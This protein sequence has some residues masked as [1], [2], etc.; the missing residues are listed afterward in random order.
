M[1]ASVPKN[2]NFGDHPVRV[3]VRD[4][5]PWF[6]ATDVCA[7]LDYKNASKAVGDH[8]DDDERMTIAANESH[9][10]DSNQSL[11]SS[12][13]RGGARS[14]VIINE[15]GLYALVLRSRKPEARKFAKWVTS[16]VLPQIRKT[17]AYLPKEFAVNPGDILTK[18]QQ[19]VL[20]QLVKST[21][22]RMPKAKQGAVAVKMWS[23]L[24]AHFGVGYREIPQQE[25]TEAVSLLTRAATEWKLVEDE[26][27]DVDYL[28]LHGHNPPAEA[29]PQ[30]IE[31]ALERKAW[32]MTREAY[33]LSKEHLRRRVA[34]EALTGWPKRTLNSELAMRAINAGG[35][36]YALTHLWRKKVEV[37]EYVI[38]THLQ[39]VPQLAEH[40]R[41][42]PG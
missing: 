15:S 7:A 5:E 31:D 35:L 26:P 6:V 18:Q 4:C 39:A 9:S 8:L 20:R 38:N 34:H 1:T 42:M 23:K 13:G 41:R 12:C 25:F 40:I 29:F 32:E 11:E 14:L 17:G 19:E 28:M 3:V 24:K 21:V 37:L 22:D 16:E 10:N 36:G 2:F 27:I 30:D 33:E